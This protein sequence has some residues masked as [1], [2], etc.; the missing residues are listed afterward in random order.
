MLLQDRE[1]FNKCTEFLSAKL[2]SGPYACLYGSPK[3]AHRIEENFLATQHRGQ[4]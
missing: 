3:F 4:E 2:S 1:D